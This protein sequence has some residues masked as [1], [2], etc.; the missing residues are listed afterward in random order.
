MTPAENMIGYLRVSSDEQA[1]S[2]A[3]LQAQQDKILAR[4]PGIPIYRDEGVS[5]KTLERPAL[6]E[7]LNEIASGRAGGLVVAK[8]DRLTRS[9]IDFANLLEWFDETQAAL[10]ALDFDLDTSTPSGRLIATILAGVAAWERETI[11][12]RTSDA[13]R[14]MQAQGKA[15]GPPAV[16]ASTR[17][18]IC[19]LRDEGLTL[20]QIAARLN[21]EE[22]PTA[23]GGQWAP[24]VVNA[25]LGAK[26]RRPRR[27]ITALPKVGAKG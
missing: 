1:A 18:L 9:V 6:M 15:I 22:V 23:R 24:S 25:A 17:A 5:G 4:H 10:V 14:A 16:S 8:L 2:G 12:Q 21:A 13:L 27:K 19:G 20:R 11:A 3:G 7:A 26:R